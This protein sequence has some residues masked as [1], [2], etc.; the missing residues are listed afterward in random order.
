ME[1]A[2]GSW[3]RNTCSVADD[4]DNSSQSQIAQTYH[5]RLVINSYNHQESGKSFPQ[6]PASILGHP[7]G[8]TLDPLTNVVRREMGGDGWITD[9]AQI[10]DSFF[11]SG[12]RGEMEGDYGE[13]RRRQWPAC[14]QQ[15][16]RSFGCFTT[17]E[18]RTED[19]AGWLLCTPQKK[20]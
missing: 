3:I 12:G 13:E 19:H 10:R 7:G 4:K 1:A 9:A 2:N 17:A 6:T 15:P 16:K 8:E 14:V 11:F 5:R 18:S 20:T